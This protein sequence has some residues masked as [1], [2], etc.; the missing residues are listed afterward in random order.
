MAEEGG[1][2]VSIGG[3]GWGFGAISGGMGMALAKKENRRNKKATNLAWERSQENRRAVQRFQKKMSNT[4]YQRSM[5]D[6]RK[7]GLNPILAYQQGGA[8]QPSGAMGSA[9]TAKVAS[10][11]HI[12]KDML[13]GLTLQAELDNTRATTAYT[14]AQRS[15]TDTRNLGEGYANTGKR[16]RAEVQQGIRDQAEKLRGLPGRAKRELGT[17]SRKAQ[18]KIEARKREGQRRVDEM[19]KFKNFNQSRQNYNRGSSMGRP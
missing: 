2:G 15:L 8:S 18:R 4:A 19:D 17:Q 3:G 5:A 1:G 11:S 14:N 6:M 9:P 12:P 10:M 16:I 7:A 13:S